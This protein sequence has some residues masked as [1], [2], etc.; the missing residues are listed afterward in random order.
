MERQFRFGW[1]MPKWTSKLKPIIDHWRSFQDRQV[2]RI[3]HF[4][5][6]DMALLMQHTQ[7][8]T[9]GRYHHQNPISFT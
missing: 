2:A 1:F 3:F 9:T 4:D 8:P 5:A 6:D 7:D